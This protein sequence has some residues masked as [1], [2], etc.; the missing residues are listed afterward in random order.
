MPII[1]AALR[2][3]GVS[4]TFG[5]TT[6]IVQTYIIV[7]GSRYD[8]P[9]YIYANATIPKRGYLYSF[10]NDGSGYARCK[11]VA[12]KCLGGYGKEENGETAQYAWEAV[13]TFDSAFKE[14][15]ENPLEKETVYSW[16]QGLKEVVFDR[17]AETE[18]PVTNSA[19]KKFDPPAMREAADWSLVATRNEPTFDA[20]YANG[21]S[22]RVN[23]DGFLG[24]EIGQWKVQGVTADSQWDETIGEYWTISYTFAFR[25]E[26]WNEDILDQ[27]RDELVSATVKPHWRPILD[28]QG[29][30]VAEPVLLD[31][32]GKPLTPEEIEAGEVEYVSFKRYREAT[33]A[34]LGL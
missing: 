13:C 18:K 23:G 21:F 29:A 16:R 25:E 5:E 32:A 7:V 17:D 19:K 26:G 12:L 30:P 10:G 3:A 1:S 14:P 6:E 34:S 24:A 20:S 28:A 22:N 33:F 15:P 27:G 9:V 2:P 31:G 4:A 11:T 8:G